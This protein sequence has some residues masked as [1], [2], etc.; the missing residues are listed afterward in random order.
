VRSPRLANVRCLRLGPESG[1]DYQAFHCFF[2]STTAVGLVRGMPRLEE[3]YLFAN[4]FDLN[5]LFA[6]RT[7]THLRVLQVYHVSQVHRLQLLA[8]NP[9]ARGLTHLLLHPHCISWW[10]NQQQ[11]E[12]AGY[13]REEGYL[14]LSAVRPL[15][16]SANLPNLKHL[17]LRVSSMGDAGCEEIVNS[18][19][20]KRLKVLDL[21]HGRITEQG[22]RTLAACPDLRRLEWLDLDRNS[23]NA[24]GI[25]A[26]KA[27]GVPV[28]I[29]DQHAVGVAD[30]GYEAEYLHEGEF[31]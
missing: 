18:G 13:R 26:I 12:A 29:D 28:R 20:L 25:E 17:R 10:E 30:A 2:H 23:I 6:L 9:A 14:P 31:E 22:A 15:L 16:H 27:V 19:I 1:D 11:D 4:G 24:A 7:L 5:E 3:L 21:R 8:E